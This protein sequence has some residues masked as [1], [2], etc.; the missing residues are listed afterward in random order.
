MIQETPAMHAAL[1]RF[2]Y[3]S[4][5]AIPGSSEQVEAEIARIIE[6]SRN[7]NAEAGLTGAL[8]RSGTVFT[9]VLEGP[10]D[11]LEAAYDRISAD[12]R[13]AEFELIEF[14]PVPERGFGSWRMAYLAEDPTGGWRGDL[15]GHA[16]PGALLEGLATRIHRLIGTRPPRQAQAQEGATSASPAG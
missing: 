2:V 6:T 11:A 1:F 5:V 8:V 9:Q 10:L 15:T 3:R 14:V 16:V 13:H 7:R 12:L 4:V